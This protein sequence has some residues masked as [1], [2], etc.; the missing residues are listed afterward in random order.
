[1]RLIAILTE[2]APPAQ[3]PS[4][5]VD[6]TRLSRRRGAYSGVAVIGDESK[7]A[8]GTDG[9]VSNIMDELTQKLEND[10]GGYFDDDVTLRCGRKYRVSRQGEA[11][12]SQVIP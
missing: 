3:Q 7:E 8:Y 4:V 11:L 6:L 12:V 5:V 2:T 10:L 9:S 1:M